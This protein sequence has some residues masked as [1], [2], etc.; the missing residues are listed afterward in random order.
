M[1]DEARL[2]NKVNDNSTMQAYSNIVEALCQSSLVGIT[3][4]YIKNRQQCLK[5]TWHEFHDLLSGLSGFTLNQSTK[6]FEVED[7]VWDDLIKVKN[8]LL[9]FKI[10]NPLFICTFVLMHF[11]LTLFSSKTHIR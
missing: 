11:A 7:E 9:P 1:I 8:A 10:E 4:I 5:D 2:G 6:T 3:K